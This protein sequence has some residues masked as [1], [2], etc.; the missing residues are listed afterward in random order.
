[1]VD[2]YSSLQKLLFR[3]DAE[4]THNCVL[5]LLNLSA[6]GRLGKRWRERLPDSPVNCL[7]LQFRNPVGLAAGLDKN[8]CLLYT[9]PSPRDATLSRMPSSA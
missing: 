9:S 7:G 4:K 1:M 6:G 5:P 8:A 2:M 3:F